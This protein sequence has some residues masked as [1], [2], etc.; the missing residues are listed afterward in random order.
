MKH[1]EKIAVCL[2]GGLAL[3]AGLRAATPVPAKH[4]ASAINRVSANTISANNS[5]SAN[6]AINASP[7]NPYM[8]IAAR[9]IFG[10]NPPAP[11]GPV[12]NPED[13]LPKITP[14]GIMGVFGNLQVLFKVGAAKPTPADK[15]E[16]YT[17][18]EGQRQDGIEVIKID[19]KKSLVTFDNNGITQELP[20]AEPGASG[21][22]APAKAGGMN[23]G[24]TQG[25]PGAGGNAGSGGITRFG[26]EPGGNSGGTP[27]SNPG[28][29]GG[30]PDGAN[31]GM[32][33]GG[34]VAPTQIYQPEP[35]TMTAEEAAIITAAQHR[36]AIDD[37]DP[38]APLFP[39]T[40]IDKEA[41]I[42]TGNP[43][44]NP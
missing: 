9:N 40:P 1:F 19:D 7:D 27:N 24:I 3:N 15:D 30:E 31:S 39:T 16:Y 14:E 36:K 41:G 32:N 2:A 22:A 35:S 37:G 17:L 25:A 18:R 33:F 34:S 20:L 6:S 11:P 5:A 43:P 26:T 12:V 23:P 8:A 4:P 38:I 42:N 21:A 44:P 10:L 13:N 28:S 29:N